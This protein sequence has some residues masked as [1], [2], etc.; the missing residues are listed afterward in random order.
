MI[1]IEKIHK[2][3]LL[4]FLATFLLNGCED[5]WDPHKGIG[6]LG[7]LEVSVDTRLSKDSNG[8]YHLTVD[9]EKWQTLHRFSGSVLSD[10]EPLD[11]FRVNWESSHF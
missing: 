3:I 10:N 11:V 5:G 6:G 9:R 4:I 8:Y 1:N 7:E 2:N